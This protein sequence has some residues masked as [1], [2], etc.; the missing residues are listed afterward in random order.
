MLTLMM[1]IMSQQNLT[2]QKDLKIA[3]TNSILERLAW[4]QILFQRLI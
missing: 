4:S 2:F 3:T 1:V